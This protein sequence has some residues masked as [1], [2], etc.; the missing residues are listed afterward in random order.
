MKLPKLTLIGVIASL[1]ATG[2]AL[3]ANKCIGPDG[4]VS[5]QDASC[6]IGSKTSEPI[7]LRENTIGNGV[8]RQPAPERLVFAQSRPS[9]FRTAAAAIDVLATNGSDCEIELKVRPASEQA[10]DSCNRYLAQHSQW[11][12]PARRELIAALAD[13]DWFAQ[14]ARDAERAAD[15]TKKVARHHAFINLYIRNTR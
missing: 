11:F 3:A 6:P 5:F 7:R 15:T 9:N 10:A 14:N 2:C 8:G 13:K 12:E 1:L 4:Q